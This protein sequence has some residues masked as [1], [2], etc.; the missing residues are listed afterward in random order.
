MMRASDITCRDIAS[1]NSTQGSNLMYFIAGYQAG[2]QGLGDN[3]TTS[4]N[5]SATTGTGSTTSEKSG[6]TGSES[7]GSDSTSK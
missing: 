6:T 7:S 2:M 5:S 1:M 4:S 3:M